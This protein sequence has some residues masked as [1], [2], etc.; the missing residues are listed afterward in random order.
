[1]S[2]D[3]L[4]VFDFWTT[5]EEGFSFAVGEEQPGQEHGE[6]PACWR[7]DLTESAAQDFSAHDDELRHL[8][9]KLHDG[10]VDE[11]SISE[12]V[13][14]GDFS[15]SVTSDEDGRL[16]G[17]SRKLTRLAFVETTNAGELLARTTINW[18]GDHQ[19]IWLTEEPEL[20][21]LHQRQVA[22]A[23]RSRLT[24]IKI[25]TFV[26]RVTNRLGRLDPRRYAQE[27]LTSLAWKLVRRYLRAA[28]P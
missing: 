10:A 23:T 21:R 3:A 11:I 4:E 16:V 20:R 2:G 24:L 26:L 17:L 19:T 5:R 15:F 14:A 13:D 9:A 8:D 6:E 28:V 25:L 7:F 12:E 27:Q 18:D 1:M 22:H